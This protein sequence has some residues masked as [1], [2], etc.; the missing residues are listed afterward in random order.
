M[1]QNFADL[2]VVDS[3]F[4]N[5]SAG[6]SPLL[7]RCIIVMRKQ[8]IGYKEGTNK[9]DYKV[10]EILFEHQSVA[11]NNV[12]KILYFFKTAK[13]NLTGCLH[14]TLYGATIRLTWL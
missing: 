1:D 11:N 4:S 6:D 3:G 2:V 10:Q 12:F 9:H 14:K 8:D 13:C 5:L 7:D